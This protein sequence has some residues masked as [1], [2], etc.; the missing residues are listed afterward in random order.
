MPEEPRKSPPPIT[1]RIPKH[2]STAVDVGSIV[3]KILRRTKQIEFA[4]VTGRDFD[5]KPKT[6]MSHTV[7]LTHAELDH[8]DNG[9]KIIVLHACGFQPHIKW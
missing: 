7:D 6:K 9:G 1:K 3:W 5:G 2:V 8:L 4:I